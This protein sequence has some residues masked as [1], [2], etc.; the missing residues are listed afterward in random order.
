MSTSPGLQRKRYE[1][2][3]SQADKGKPFSMQEATAA[4]KEQPHD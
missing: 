4:L 1:P 3:L 2:K